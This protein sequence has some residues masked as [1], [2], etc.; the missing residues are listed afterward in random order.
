MLD[1]A[2]FYEHVG[3]DHLWE[4]G[5]KTS[6]P[7]RLLACWCASY[8]DWRFLEADKCATFP[9]WAFGTILPGCSGATTAAKLM[10]ATLLETVSSRLPSYRLWN[11]VDEISEHVVGSPRMVQVSTAEVA[12][13]LV[14]GLQ[15]RDLPLSRGKSKVL[16]DGPDKLKQGLLRQL[17]AQGIDETDSARNVGA[18]LLLGRRRRASVVKGRLAKTAK[19]SRRTRPLRKAGAHTR[20]VTLTGSNAGVLGDPRSWASPLPTSSPS[21][22]MR[23]KPPSGS[24]EDPMP[25]LRGPRTST[26][27]F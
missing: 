21:E 18:D 6:F 12:R 9:F 7:R 11:V 19:R 13:L 8:E 4:E 27:A 5:I 25:R 15:A 26:P 24:A 16:I 14:E 23:P 10:L 22:S 3:H 1:L 20:N 2:K 17:E